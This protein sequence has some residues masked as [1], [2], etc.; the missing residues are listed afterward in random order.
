MKLQIMGDK[1][2]EKQ[3]EFFIQI[4]DFLDDAGIGL[5]NE[6]RKSEEYKKLLNKFNEQVPSIDDD[7]PKWILYLLIYPSGFN[8]V[9]LYYHSVPFERRKLI[10]GNNPLTVMIDYQNQRKISNDQLI[11][12]AKDMIEEM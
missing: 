1:P 8:S 7:T 4:R 3:T 11:Q 2:T 10:F 12:Y 9:Y 5:S 6:L